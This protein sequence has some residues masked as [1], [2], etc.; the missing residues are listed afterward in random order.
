[1]QS[2]NRFGISKTQTPKRNQ[3]ENPEFTPG[4]CPQVTGLR[5]TTGCI[6]LKRTDKKTDGLKA[7][8]I[9]TSPPL[10]LKLRH[11]KLI[12]EHGPNFSKFG[13]L[14]HLILKII[15]FTNK[16]NNVLRVDKHMD[17]LTE[18]NFTGTEKIKA[19][20]LVNLKFLINKHF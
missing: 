7:F 10:E 5:N 11:F 6:T 19:K 20:F 3:S 8:E 16:I 4:I 13:C 2:Q 14:I 1:M 9:K 17:H 15:Y 12:K 18:I